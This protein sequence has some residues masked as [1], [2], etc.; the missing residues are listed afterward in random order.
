MVEDLLVARD[1]I[2]SHQTVRIWAEKFG[3][4]F[5]N[6]SRRRSAGKLGDKW[7]LDELV[8]TIG[9]KKHW[10]WRA[11]DQ[12]GFIL[13]GLVQNRLNAKAAKIFDAQ[14]PQSTKPRAACN[15]H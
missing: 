9:G 12:N 3:R 11:V 6:D 4:R 15:G 1:V 2:F 8:I 13:D 7:H 10:L 14:A 5:A